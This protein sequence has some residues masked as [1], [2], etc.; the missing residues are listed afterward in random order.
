MI[1]V[2]AQQLQQ[3]ILNLVVNAF[4]A[5]PDGGELCLGVRQEVSPQEGARLLFTLADTG[6][7]IPEENLEAIFD[8]FYTTKP[9]GSGF[10][11]ALA[12]TMVNQ[13]KGNLTVA[14]TPGKGSVFTLALPLHS[15][16]AAAARVAM[17]G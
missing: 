3:V 6:M 13:S 16:P 10:G 9:R 2:D 14:S 5:M 4:E 11:L 15:P 17:G 8:P 1:R 12:N 7:G